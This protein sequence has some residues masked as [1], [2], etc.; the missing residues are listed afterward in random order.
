MPN[1]TLKNI[2]HLIPDYEP[3]ILLDKNGHRIQKN[4]YDWQNLYASFQG[5]QKEVTVQ[6]IESYDEGIAIRVNQQ[7]FLNAGRQRRYAIH[8]AYAIEAV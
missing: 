4:N 3:V 5:L 7:E 2:R 6:K 8:P 1:I